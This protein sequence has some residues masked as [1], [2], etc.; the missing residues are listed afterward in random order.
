MR[1]IFPILAFMGGMAIAFQDKI[2]GGL[3][4]KIGV[5]EGALTS[6]TTGAITLLFVSIFWG[7]GDIS[8][9]TTVPKWQLIGGMLGAFY[10]TAMVFV[11][12]KIGVTLT[13]MSVIIGQVLIAML[14]DHFGLFGGMRMPI[15][16]R[17]LAAIFL[18]FVSAYLILDE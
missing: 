8:A 12:P 15:N 5:I 9:I 2:N 11:V 4:K 18:F 6:F 3:G 7:K 1:I 13:V 10:V 14:I 16:E 17:K